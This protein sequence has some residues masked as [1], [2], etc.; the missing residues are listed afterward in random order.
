MNTIPLLIISVLANLDAV[1]VSTLAP[2]L[3]VDSHP[4][5]AKYVKFLLKWK[6]ASNWTFVV[7]SGV[8]P[9]AIS[10][11]F[12]FFLPI[13]MRWLTRVFTHTFESG[14]A[15]TCIPAV[16]GCPYTLQT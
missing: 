9:P 15:L 1:R 4:Q 13:I 12:G 7:V 11:I 6:A 10:G 2:A 16:H 3:R 5:L 8:L 14:H